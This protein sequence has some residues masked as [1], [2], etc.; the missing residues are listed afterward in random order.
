MSKFIV[1]YKPFNIPYGKRFVQLASTAD[2]FTWMSTNPPAY[3]GQD[4]IPP[5]DFKR[6]PEITDFCQRNISLHVNSEGTVSL[7]GWLPAFFDNRTAGQTSPADKADRLPSV[8]CSDGA[9]FKTAAA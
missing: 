2:L 7:T 8:R 6:F 4:I 5:D 3:P 9:N 1:G